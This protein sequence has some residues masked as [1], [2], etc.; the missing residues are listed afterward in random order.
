MRVVSSL[1][2]LTVV[3][4]NENNYAYEYDSLTMMSEVRELKQSSSLSLFDF[5]FARVYANLVHIN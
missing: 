4:K 3:P 5:L 1:D 2:V